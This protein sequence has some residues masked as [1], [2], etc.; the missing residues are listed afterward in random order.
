MLR[1]FP[2]SAPMGALTPMPAQNMRCDGAGARVKLP[3]AA[4]V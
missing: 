1:R 2:S 4:G 3:A